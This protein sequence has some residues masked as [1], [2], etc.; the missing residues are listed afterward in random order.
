V[1]VVVILVV[2]GGNGMRMCSEAFDMMSACIDQEYSLVT[3]SMFKL[4]HLTL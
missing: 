2:M 3:I 4:L 1:V